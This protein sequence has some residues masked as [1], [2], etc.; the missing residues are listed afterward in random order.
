MHHNKNIILA[1]YRIMFELKL[2]FS[3]LLWFASSDAISKYM[4]INF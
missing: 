4:L 1:I 3:E 2:K